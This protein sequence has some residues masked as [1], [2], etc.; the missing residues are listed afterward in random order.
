MI[1]EPILFGLTGTVVKVPYGFQTLDFNFFPS[2][3]KMSQF[4]FNFQINELDPS[5]VGYGIAIISSGVI[6]RILATIGIAFGDNLNTKEKVMH[7]F[8]SQKTP[9]LIKI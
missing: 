7:Q 1:F 9:L 8:L 6:I 3:L 4:V 5:V 2:A